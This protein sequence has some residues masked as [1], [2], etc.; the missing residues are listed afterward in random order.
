MRLE[1][2]LAVIKL[3]HLEMRCNALIKDQNNLAWR[4]SEEEGGAESAEGLL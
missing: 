4:G 3:A 1:R 2:D